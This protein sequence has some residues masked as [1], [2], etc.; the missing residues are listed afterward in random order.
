[1]GFKSF[2]QKTRLEFNKGITAVVGPNGSGKSNVADAVKWVLGEQSLKS[3]RGKKSEDVI[4]AGSKEKAK[5]GMAEVSLFLNNED[6]Q[7]PI[8]FPEVVITRRLYRNGDSEYLI[9]KNQARLMDIQ[10]LLLKSGFGQK[11]Y[12]VIGQGQIGNILGATPQARKEMFDEAAGVKQFHVKRDSALR[13]LDRTKQ[14]L[15]RVTDLLRELKPR[16]G[17]LQKQAEKAAKGEVLERELHEMQTKLF[18]HLWDKFSTKLHEADEVY[19]K[20]QQ[21]I[22]K[23][24]AEI[25]SIA[26]QIEAE[27]KRTGSSHTEQQEKQS[28][29]D[30]ARNQQNQLQQNLAL[31]KGK[32]DLEKEKSSG[33][34]VSG[35]QIELR[36]KQTKRAA[37]QKQIES[38]NIQVKGKE[39]ELKT[40]LAE[41]EKLNQDVV[42]IQ[43]GIQKLQLEMQ[44]NPQ[45]AGDF[46]LEFA[47]LEKDMTS[48]AEKIAACTSLEEL[49]ILKDSASQLSKKL[50]QVLSKY[51]K[52]NGQAK[53]EQ[54]DIARLQASLNETTAKRESLTNAIN[55]LKVAIASGQAELN[56]SQAQIEIL[57]TD[58]QKLETKLKAG[59]K[60]AD[61][62]TEAHANLLSSEKKLTQEL[63]SAEKI[64]QEKQ[65]AFDE[66]NRQE[67]ANKQTVFALERQ[68]R[69]L[70]NS[71]NSKRV[72]QN[73]TQIERA[74]QQ[75]RREDIERE[76][77]E[78]LGEEAEAI[79]KLAE[80]KK[81]RALSKDQEQ[82]LHQKINKHKRQLDIIG[83]IDPAVI[84]EHKQLNE[85]VDFLD[86]QSSDLNDA[87]NKLKSVIK[88]L[89]EKI[90]Q[91]FDK[92]FQKINQEFTKYFKILFGGGEAKLTLIRQV[93]EIKDEEDKIK[94][95]MVESIDIKAVPPGKKLKS[96]SMLSGGEKTMTS[97]AL[98]MAI[99]ANNP[100][101]FIVLDEVDAALDEANSRRYARILGK[102]AHNTQF[103]L[104]THNREAMRQAGILYGVTMERNGVS[105]IISI[106]LE[107][108]EELAE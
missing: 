89:D 98:L 5:M 56:A 88:E 83:G 104:I 96:T 43:Q 28:A 50:E 76:M 6:G 80:D 35:L 10:D 16:L 29:V 100:S 17:S 42:N 38:L 11:T 15:L 65:A 75:T 57:K 4:F 54:N 20:H 73:E 1:Q 62:I 101:P 26:E 103:I 31:T 60:T 41:Q 90:K 92:A 44:S 107:K 63:A 74:K 36:D 46:E 95:E 69:E 40:K 71:L 32:I 3:I 25:K 13:K 99:I 93:R 66:F 14:N 55:S 47:A 48:F 27:E 85:R 77:I 53:P 23:I 108:A 84:D 68:Y 19:Q 81:H 12:S 72:E 8:D 58:C 21:E 33:V 64:L 34:D 18:T 70:Q 9:N 78:E 45:A 30:Q 49:E 2:A 82:A 105:K 106:K 91:Q 87:A 94:R 97:I 59:E 22:D 102:L 39:K 52:I 61:G 79:K 67:Q 24:D 37:L 86:T 7:M 51:K